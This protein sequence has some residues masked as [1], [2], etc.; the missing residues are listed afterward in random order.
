MLQYLISFRFII[1][2]LNH[3]INKFQV[4]MIFSKDICYGGS[5]SL[6]KVYIHGICMHTWKHN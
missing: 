1:F 5:T 4:D 3:D 2:N 6:L